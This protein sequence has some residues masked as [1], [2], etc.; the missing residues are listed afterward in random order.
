[1][2]LFYFHNTEISAL[3]DYVHH[4]YQWTTAVCCV[5]IKTSYFVDVVTLSEAVT[6]R[7]LFEGSVWFHTVT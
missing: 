5:N 6:Y 1:M 7:A 2:A 4:M 3:A